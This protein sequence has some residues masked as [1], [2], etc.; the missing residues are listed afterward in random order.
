L[1]LNIR[2]TK[3]R[4]IFSL[5]KKPV[6]EVTAAYDDKDKKK[7]EENNE[8]LAAAAKEVA[9]YE[10]TDDFKDQKDKIKSLEEKISIQEELLS[11]LMGQLS[12]SGL[13]H[14]PQALR[15]YENMLT[16]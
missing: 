5:F 8:Q 9:A 7:V 10:E 4:G 15:K 14:R 1:I 6:T 16:R 13:S 2:K 12:L 11:K 3:P